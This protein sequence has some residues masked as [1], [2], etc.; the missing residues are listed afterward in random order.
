MQK[1]CAHFERPPDLNDLD[2]VSVVANLLGKFGLQIYY[3]VVVQIT[4][5]KYSVGK[6]VRCH[7]DATI[8]L[9]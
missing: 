3:L 7:D 6:A 9:R 8:L 2:N 5:L 1:N 4:I